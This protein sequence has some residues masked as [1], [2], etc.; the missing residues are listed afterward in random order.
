MPREVTATAQYIRRM[1]PRAP[2]S[3][4]LANRRICRGGHPRRPLPIRSYGTPHGRL[5]GPIGHTAPRTLPA[6]S[7]SFSPEPRRRSR[8]RPRRTGEAPPANGLSV[9]I[10]GFRTGSNG[11]QL[12][13]DRPPEGPGWRGTR[14]SVTVLTTGYSCDGARPC[15][16]AGPV[17]GDLALPGQLS[18]PPRSEP[19]DCYPTVTLDP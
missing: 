18:V 17:S 16:E 7:K 6:G 1:V 4:P 12:S 13:G 11:K 19:T 9:W 15:P 8:R 10:F 14:S 2:A 3:R 5:P